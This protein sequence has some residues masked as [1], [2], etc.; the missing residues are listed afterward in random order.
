[1][2]EPDETDVHRIILSAGLA[3]TIAPR[4]IV[5]LTGIIM[6][7]SGHAGDMPNLHIPPIAEKIGRI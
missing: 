7:G 3:I 6:A 5:A 2:A 4:S 1:L